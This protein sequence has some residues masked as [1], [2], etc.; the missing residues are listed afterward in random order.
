MFLGEETVLDQRSVYYHLNLCVFFSEHL[1]KICSV[2]N[3]KHFI[4]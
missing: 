4:T 2:V 3:S 1:L